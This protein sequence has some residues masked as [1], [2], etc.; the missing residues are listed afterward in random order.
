MKTLVILAQK[1]GSGKS[2]LAVHLAAWAM[3]HGYSTAI[4]DLDP[5]GTAHNWNERRDNER[6]VQAAKIKAAQLPQYLKIAKDE[7]QHLVLIDTA[8]HAN[9]EAAIAAQF[10][11]FILI[12]CR[13]SIPDL[14]TVANSAQ[15]AKA[16]RKP[17][18]VVLSAA[19]RGRV[20]DDA[21]AALA[22]IQVPVLETVI[23]NRIAYSHAMN[24]GRAV[25]EYEPGGKAAVEIEALYQDISGKLGLTKL[26]KAG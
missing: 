16:V 25:Y 2:T 5:Q 15:I 13:P 19:P 10:A 7:K 17:F 22:E 26:K 11:D 24:D 4:L 3:Q 21:R 8:P 14:E 18:A 6:Q 1:G 23:Y 9:N 12:P 20:V